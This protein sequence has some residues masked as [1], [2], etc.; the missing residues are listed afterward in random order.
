MCT[1]FWHVVVPTW[2]SFKWVLNCFRTIMCSLAASMLA[3]APPREHEADKYVVWNI[4]RVKENK[5]SSVRDSMEIHLDK[6]WPILTL[7]P[8]KP[9]IAILKPW[10]SWPNKLLTGTRQSSNITCLVGWEFQPIYK[11]H[12]WIL[13]K[14]KLKFKSNM[15]PRMV[16]VC[17]K[18]RNVNDLTSA[19]RG[20]FCAWIGRREISID[21]LSSGSHSMPKFLFGIQ[22]RYTLNL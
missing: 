19:A 16:A 8:F 5:F 7:P 4:T 22:W 18:E 21:C 17:Q 11:T 12:G 20:L 15:Q 6:C 13:P 14:D 9:F 2:K 1:Y 3:C 10:P